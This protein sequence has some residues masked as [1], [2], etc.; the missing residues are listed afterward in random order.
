VQRMNGKIDNSSSK[1]KTIDL[2]IQI[3]VKLSCQKAAVRAEPLQMTTAATLQH[4]LLI[5]TAALL[6]TSNAFQ[7]QLSTISKF[8]RT[9]DVNINHLP[10]RDVM[11]NNVRPSQSDD[12][13]NDLQLVST[14]CTYSVRPACISGRIIYTLC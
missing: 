3:P 4:V 11:L 5:I 13:P 9:N 8:R 12:E 14:N 10:R 7:V 1:V 6:S 2:T